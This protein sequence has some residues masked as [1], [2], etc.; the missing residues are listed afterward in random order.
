VN[1]AKFICIGTKAFVGGYSNK[2]GVHIYEDIIERRNPRPYEPGVN[3]G[4]C[5]NCRIESA[6]IWFNKIT[7]DKFHNTS[8]D[9]FVVDRNI[10]AYK[11]A[12][13]YK[14]ENGKSILF[15]SNTWGNGKTHLSILREYLRQYMLNFNLW[16]KEFGKKH[17]I[18]ANMVSEA[19][20][21]NQIRASFDNDDKEKK[22]E[23]ENDIINRYTNVKLL[24]LDDIGKTTF[25]KDDFLNRVYYLIIDRLYTKKISLIATC[26]GTMVNIGKQVG[27]AAL[28]RL[29]EMCG[30]NRI[31]ITGPDFRRENIKEKK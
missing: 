10:T 18:P 9:T 26:N 17:T 28:S 13:G 25:A 1:K 11:S 16:E 21:I 5:D 7:N 6:E 2:N 20:L 24:L 3:H 22:I 27:Q 29:Y 19:E 12:K 15:W 14:A 31:E 8:F 4:L 30:N 23:S